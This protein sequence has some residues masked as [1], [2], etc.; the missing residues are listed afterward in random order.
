MEFST[1]VSDAVVRGGDKRSGVPERLRR[2][3]PRLALLAAALCALLLAPGLPVRATQPVPDGVSPFPTVLSGTLVFQSDRPGRPAIFTL[4]L[5]TGRVRQLSGSPQWT[6][7]K[8][9]WSPDGARVV[10]ASNRA[11]FE[12]PSPERGTPDLDLWTVNADGS[13]RRRVTTE[14]SNET[15]PSWAPDGQSL[16][17]SSDRDSRGDLYRVWLADGRV[18][19]LTR[20]FVGR[21]L[22]PAVSP[23]GRKVAFAA[24]T[25]HVGAFWDYQVHV[26]DLASGR[27]EP[28]A[29][30]AGACWPSWSRDGRRMANVLLPR[31][32]PSVLEERDVA[33]GRVRQ[34]GADAPLWSYYPSWSPDEA[35][36]AFSVSPAH[37]QGQDWDLAVFTFATGR[38]TR[39]TSG[40]GN[41]RLPDWK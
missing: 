29:S 36:V 11:H 35:H 26:L 20:H 40:P 24:Q 23:D 10:F 5:A 12:G 28:L 15:D 2:R 22:M 34:F 41:D 19:R 9:R 1:I 4:E 21:A 13:G 3:G 17:F 6:E 25:L 30:S 16:V 32:R 39:L 7:E 18:E 8:P 33:S 31:N 14:P 37:H 27:T 38:W